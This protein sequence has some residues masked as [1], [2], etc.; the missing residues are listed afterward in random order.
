MDANVAKRNSGIRTALIVIRENAKHIAIF[1][2]ILGHAQ[3]TK[4]VKHFCRTDSKQQ[5]G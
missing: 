2:S 5:K 1:D 4:H 3:V